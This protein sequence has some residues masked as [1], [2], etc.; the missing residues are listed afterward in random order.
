M[1][2]RRSANRGRHARHARPVPPC[3]NP[4]PAGRAG[5]PVDREAERTAELDRHS[6]AA[7]RHA[8]ATAARQ[9]MADEATATRLRLQAV[10]SRWIP[11]L[12]VA[13]AAVEQALD[14]NEHADAV[15]LRRVVAGP[16]GRPLAA[17]R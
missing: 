10:T 13:L 4:G 2:Y 6:R 11:R 14:E 8:A 1:G 15:R 3:R 12:Q 7:A 9:I 5:A 16:A 17:P